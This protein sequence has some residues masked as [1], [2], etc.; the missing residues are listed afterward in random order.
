MHPFLSKIYHIKAK[1][2]SFPIHI[3]VYFVL[4]Y[5]LCYNDTYQNVSNIVT[6]FWVTIYISYSLGTKS[7]EKDFLDFFG[8]HMSHL[9]DTTLEGHLPRCYI[10]CELTQ[11]HARMQ[12]TSPHIDVNQSQNMALSSGHCSLW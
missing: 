12:Q 8:L 7:K 10:R 1:K 4:F 2:Q 6:I 5:F 3:F 9:V 11:H